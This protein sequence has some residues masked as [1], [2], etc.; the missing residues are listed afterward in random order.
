[1]RFR[2]SAPKPDRKMAAPARRKSWG[3]FLVRC[4]GFLRVPPARSLWN[5]YG[6]Q[7]LFIS[8]RLPSPLAPPEVKPPRW[9]SRPQ[10]D[11]L[12]PFQFQMPTT[13][14]KGHAGV[15]PH[16]LLPGLSRSSQDSIA[17]KTTA[18]SIRR[19]SQISRTAP[20]DGGALS[21]RETA[22]ME[23]LSQRRVL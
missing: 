23:R 3:R 11:D 22:L 21:V 2:L 20:V 14:D 13:K 19:S 17:D 6:R 7:E 18:N 15:T 16:G 1:M 8:F 4:G 10:S 9:S 5:G 12:G